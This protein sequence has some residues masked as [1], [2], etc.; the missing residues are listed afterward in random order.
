MADKLQGEV[1]RCCATINDAF[2]VQH[3]RETFFFPDPA[4]RGV[5]IMNQIMITKQNT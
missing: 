4:T 1:K 3:W 5:L 2:I